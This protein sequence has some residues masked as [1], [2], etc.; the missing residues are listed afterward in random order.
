[1]IYFS[2]S[3]GHT[4]LDDLGI[5]KPS[6]TWTYLVNDNP[7]EKN[8]GLQLIGNTGLQISAGILGP[9]LALELFFRKKKKRT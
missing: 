8:L 1:M 4:N 7:F 2:F 5:R 3:E 9:L 6:A